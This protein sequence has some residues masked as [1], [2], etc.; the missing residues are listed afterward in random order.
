ML[1][2]PFLAHRLDNLDL[3]R[4]GRMVGAGQPEGRVALHAVIAGQAVLKHAVHRM[5]HVQLTGDVRRRHDDGKGLLAL[6][7]MRHERAVLLPLLVQLSFDGLRVIHLVHLCG[8][9]L[10]HNSIPFRL[11]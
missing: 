5:A 10:F 7:A 2:Q 1:I 11:C 8:F 9:V 6:H 3:G 4:D